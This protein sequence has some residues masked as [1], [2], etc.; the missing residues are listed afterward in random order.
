MVIWSR[1]VR[2]P[3]GEGACALRAIR[4]SRKRGA[5]TESVPAQEWSGAGAPKDRRKK[6]RSN[7]RK[8]WTALLAVL[9]AVAVGFG[10]WFAFAPAARP[11]NVHAAEGYSLT[12][13]SKQ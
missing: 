11:A 9:F 13:K 10:L 3:R 5:G 7:V 6:M 2:C 12:L 8:M 1:I 4:L